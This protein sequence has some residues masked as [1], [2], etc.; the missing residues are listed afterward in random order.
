M[1][2]KV[3]QIQ[4]EYTRT[5]KNKKEHMYYRNQNVA[6]LQCD[7][8]SKKFERRVSQMDPRRLNTKYVHVCS[9]CNPKQFAQSKGVENRKFWNT[10]VDLD[11]D[12]DKI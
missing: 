3:Y 4:V 9:E 12:I 2:I 6:L 1:L 8:C 5:S 10:T 11:L 7:A